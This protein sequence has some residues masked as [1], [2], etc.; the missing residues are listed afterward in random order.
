MNADFDDVVLQSQHA[1]DMKSYWRR[2]KSHE[3]AKQAWQHAGPQ[4]II[5]LQ[6]FRI[7]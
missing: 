5:G 2:Q 6:G 1:P 7:C 3:N 4:H